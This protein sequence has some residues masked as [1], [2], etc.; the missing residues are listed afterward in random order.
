[1]IKILLIT[2]YYPSHKGGVEIAA[3][4]TALNIL[5]SELNHIDW[6]AMDR[7][8]LP[9]N[10]KSLTFKPIR[11]LNFI[12]KILPFPYPIPT[13]HSIK[14]IYDGVKNCD[15]LHI[16]EFLYFANIIAFL[17]A[18]KLKKKVIITQHVGMIPYNNPILRLILSTINKTFGK[19][20]LQKADK[21]VF[22]SNNVKNY[23]EEFC[24]NNNFYL[25][26]N[27]VNV[28]Q[29]ISYPDIKKNFLD[30]ELH[31][32]NYSAKMLFV[33]RFTEKK[34]IPLIVELA[35][36]F[37]TILWIFVGW[38]KIDPMKSGLKNVKVFKDIDHKK[39]TDFYNIADYLILPSYGEGFPL[40]IQ[41]A[42]S[43]GLPVITTDENAAA[44]PDAEKYMIKLSLKNKNNWINLIEKINSKATLFDYSQAEL[45]N[46]AK[47]HWSE[48]VNGKFYNGLIKELLMD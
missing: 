43:C 12:E 27:S 19:Y 22:I 11:M 37:P 47:E 32:Q 2:H 6:L 29:F 13:F 5:S 4:K 26:A 39:V 23:F 16:H 18:K 31:S 40:V 14:K 34:G 20:I 1:M 9:E 48:E 46:F 28:R 10:S 24:N 33:G 45:R 44:H 38:G 42:F 41:E 36:N 25:Q 7:D 15:L 17:Y 35:R 3:H 21:V 30:Y 8:V